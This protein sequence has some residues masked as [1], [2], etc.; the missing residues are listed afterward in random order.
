MH[1]ITL[2]A[3]A[4]M[5]LSVAATAQVPP[6]IVYQDTSFTPPRPGYETRLDPMTGFGGSASSTLGQIETRPHTTPG[7]FR[8]AVSLNDPQGGFPGHQGDW[9][10]LEAIWDPEGKLGPP[11]IHKTNR[12]AVFNTTRFEFSLSISHDGLVGVSDNWFWPRFATRASPTQAFASPTPRVTGMPCFSG[13]RTCGG[14]LVDSTLCQIDGQLCWAYI[15]LTGDISTSD[16]DPFGWPNLTNQVRRLSAA[17]ATTTARSLF[18]PRALGDANGDALAFTASVLHGDGTFDFDFDTYFFPSLDNAELNAAN[19]GLLIWEDGFGQ[20]SGGPR[21]DGGTL[22]IPHHTIAP[23]TRRAPLNLSIVA[24]NGGIMVPGQPKTMRVWVPNDGASGPWLAGVL[25][26]VT[27]IQLPLG[28]TKGNGLGNPR[29]PGA[30]GVIPLP[31]PV[32]APVATGDGG[33]TFRFRTPAATP[34]GLGP[35][36]LT[37]SFALNT[38]NQDLFLGNTA[39][40]GT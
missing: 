32:L 12:A 22:Y 7:T 10:V 24:H 40:L 34:A 39:W 28:F 17:T 16:F 20:G 27:P 14:G 38:A 3:A 19:R 36:V 13:M 8:L 29:P 31:P 26:G 6:A 35:F 4:V 9:D 33:A 23:F 5:A 1:H 2:R 15:D 25:F 30:L 18:S 21:A 11:G 37:Q